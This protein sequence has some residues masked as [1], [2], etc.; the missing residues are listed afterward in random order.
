MKNFT[1]Q[2]VVCA[3]A[4]VLSLGVICAGSVYAANKAKMENG[5]LGKLHASMDITCVQ[6]H[7]KVKKPAPV[8]ME[9]CLGCHGDTTKLAEKT[10]NAKPLN[11]HEN[12]HYGTEAD[13][14]LCHHQHKKSENFCLPCH[15]R[16]DFVVP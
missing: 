7:G 13:C 9:T 5:E 15:Q 4:L 8:S 11:P 12:R 10:A 3:I 1:L 2:K 6:C 14:N 16:F